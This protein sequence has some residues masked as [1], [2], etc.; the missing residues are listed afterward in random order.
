MPEITRSKIEDRI[1]EARRHNHQI[2]THQEQ[3][4]IEARELSEEE[5]SR[6]AEAIA[7]TNFEYQ[8]LAESQ[9]IQQRDALDDK[10]DKVGR[11]TI[12]T[13]MQ[14]TYTLAIT[15][16]QLNHDVHD[17]QENAISASQSLAKKLGSTHKTKAWAVLGCAVGGAALTMISG[18]A[19]NAFKTNSQT[20]PATSSSSPVEATLKQNAYEPLAQLANFASQHKENAHET[21]KAIGSVASNAG[22]AVDSLYAGPITQQNTELH[23][24]S[25]IETNAL[26]NTDKQVGET[27]STAINSLS[28][29]IDTDARLFEV[30][31]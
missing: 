13:V 16:Q 12:Y 2:E 5:K 17:A 29:L 4:Q 28:R 20:N 25:S 1:D 22:P 11:M 27:G 3:H 31:A 24:K 21:L 18:T 10:V 26:N 7:Q 19:A 15:L 6:L 8:Q 30:R 14:K 9:G 23:I